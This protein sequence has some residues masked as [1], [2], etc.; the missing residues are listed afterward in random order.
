MVYIWTV[1]SQSPSDGNRAALAV[2]DGSAVRS[3]YCYATFVF[4]PCSFGIGS[5]KETHG[6]KG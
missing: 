5:W 3:G 1:S 4:R 2:A 6:V